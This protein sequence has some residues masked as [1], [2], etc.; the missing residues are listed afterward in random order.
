MK[1]DFIY[2]RNYIQNI[3]TG[4]FMS[5]VITVSLNEGAANWLAP[6]TLETKIKVPKAPG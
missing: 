2:A 4:L 6:F 3:E 5:F 1:D